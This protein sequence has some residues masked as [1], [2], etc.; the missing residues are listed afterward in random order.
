MVQYATATELAGYLQEDL[1]TYT[2]NQAL[3]LA[4]GQFSQ[5]AMTWFDPQT[6]TFVTTGTPCVSINLPFRPV[7]AISAVRINGVAV[8]GYTLVKNTVWRSAGF[9]TSCVIPPDKVE[10]DLTHGYTSVPDDVKA[11]VIETAAA[12]Y[13]VPVSAVVGES[14]DDYQVRYSAAGGGV[15]LT[16]SARDLARTYRGTL[17]A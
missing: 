8:T 12:A 11:A 9:G 13:S 1:D 4:S 5:L 17:A 7:T 16:A 2:A 15:Q 6:T 10:V 14:I 3:T